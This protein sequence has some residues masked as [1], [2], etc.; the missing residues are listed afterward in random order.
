MTTTTRT[1]VPT[2]QLRARF[3]AGLSALY[4]AEVPAY[5]Q[6]VEVSGQVNA[7]VLRDRGADA[8]QLGSL[9]RVTAERHGAVRV[10]TPAELSQ[11]A[12]VLAAFGMHPVGFYDLRDAAPSPVPVVSTAFRPVDPDE[13]EQNPFRLFTSVLVPQ[14]RRF[15]DAE[16]DRR[17]QEFLSRRTLF[18]PRLLELAGRAVADGGLVQDEAEELLELAVASLALGAEPIERSWYDELQRVSSVAADIAGVPSTHINHLTPRVLDIDLLHAR[19]TGLGVQMLDRIEGP[20]RWDGPEVLL[21]QTSFRALAEQRRMREPDG[22]VVPGALR[23]RFGEVEARGV[24]L[25][26]T[27]RQ[28]YDAALAAAADRSAPDRDADEVLA[29]CWAEQFPRT[30]LDLARNGLG[31]Y[32]FT[33]TGTGG[34]AA[35][36][37]T[38]LLDT[39]LLTAS[40]VVYEDFLPKSAAGIFSSN[41]EGEGSST[42]VTEGTPRDADWL[43]GV[44]DRPVHDP[45]ELYAAQ[46]RRSLAVAAAEL[47]LR[48]I[49]DDRPGQPT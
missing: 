14:D 20:P 5:S 38:Q 27:G 2:T 4:A 36:G 47:G 9:A 21:R 22:S 7:E 30:A 10:G 33:A 49:R 12:A 3:A 46:V 44:L 40:P 31:H 35:D 6:L 26:D 34:P 18:P 17:V 23:V 8:E 37:L 13:L 45:Q 32:A 19:M 25:T 41:L 16:L 24:A 42:G 43:A 28:R 39:G 29:E 1:T 48:A 15:F 11:L